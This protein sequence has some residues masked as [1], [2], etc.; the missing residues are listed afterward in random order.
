VVVIGY[1]YIGYPILIFCLA[2]IRSLF[3]RRF[4]AAPES[5]LPALTIII[6]AYNEERF[7]EEKIQNTLAL[8]Y[9]VEKRKI[10]IVTDGSTDNTQELAKNFP[11][12]S[13]FHQDE[14]RGKIHA[15]NRTI[16]LVVTPITVF[17]DANTLLNTGALKKMARHYRDAS[18]GGV[19]GEKRI[20]SKKND[21]SAASGEGLYWRYES[22]IKKNDSD[23]YS[24][25]G[26]AGELFSIRTELFDPPSSDVII[27]DFYVSMQVAAKGY[28]FVY[29]PEAYAVEA[30]SATTLD[31]WKRKVRISAGGLQA[32][33]RLSELINPF[34][35]GALSFQYISHRVLRWTLAPFSLLTIFLSGFWLASQQI[36]FYRVLFGLQMLFY[37]AALLGYMQRERK[38][39][40][41]IFFVPF[42]F[43]MMNLAVFVGAIRFLRGK[44]SAVWE[45]TNRA[46]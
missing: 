26:A 42:Y 40:I 44:Q 33:L 1:T 17:S 12:V 3:G 8:D 37:A 2:K 31:E 45:K 39:S 16:P 10:F 43:A 46:F 21:N 30:A 29:E 24:I 38:V 6:A 28:R 23:F 25:V 35:F 18:V 9:P 36:Y 13:V 5:D 20:A 22:F 11:A 14:R 7:I 41:K 4:P 34:R 32:V 27:E 15:V 19:A